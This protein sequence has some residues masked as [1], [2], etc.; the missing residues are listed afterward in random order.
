MLTGQSQRHQR[1]FI[2]VAHWAGFEGQ[3]SK[4]KGQKIVVCQKILL[5]IVKKSLIFA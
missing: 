4:I 1:N 3:M 5:Q 2:V